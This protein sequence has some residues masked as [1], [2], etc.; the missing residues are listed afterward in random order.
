LSKRREPSSLYFVPLKSFNLITAALMVCSVAC[1]KKPNEKSE[2]AA[3]QASENPGQGLPNDGLPQNLAELHA[4]YI[5]PPE[6]RNAAIYYQKA[7]EVLTKEKTGDLALPLMGNGREKLPLVSSPIPP[8]MKSALAAF[9][10]RNQPYWEALQRASQFEQ[11]R[12]PLELNDINLAPPLL[13]K[14]REAA[15]ISVLYTLHR[16]DLG[17]GEGAAEGVLTALAAAR[18]L[19]QEPLVPSQLT[20]GACVSLAAEA[21]EQTLNR[22]S[23]SPAALEKLQRAFEHGETFDAEGPGFLRASAGE[24]AW[25]GTLFDLP[26]EAISAHFGMSTPEVLRKLADELKDSDKTK[27]SRAYY[28][29]AY[30]QFRAAYRQPFPARFK[31]G[32]G[33]PNW[34]A[35]AVRKQFILVSL[36]GFPSDKLFAAEAGFLIKERQAL[37]AIALEQFRA[38]HDNRY[39]DSLN[40]LVPRFMAGLQQS[41]FDGQPLSYSK[42]GDGYQLLSQGRDPAK[43]FS[44]QVVKSPPLPV[45]SRLWTSKD[46]RTLEAALLSRTTSTITIRRNA[47]QREFTL[48]IDALSEPDRQFLSRLPQTSPAGK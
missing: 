33:F 25:A 22:V 28:A 10:R 6:G 30:Q 42:N 48:N 19:E 39:P 36:I 17:D 35:E 41:P 31:A 32:E 38:V 7:F 29:A 46:G 16:A 8:A 2:A 5:E 34:T 11:C 18:S 44:F 9:L 14:I 15:Q 3:S 1:T 23:L 13:T 37:T 12:Y 43:S 24:S 26:P 21:L 20:R 40:E 45:P 47:D 27:A 4:W